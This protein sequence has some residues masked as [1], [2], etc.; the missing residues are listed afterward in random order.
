MVIKGATP[1]IPRSHIEK[2]LSGEGCAPREDAGEVNQGQATN[3]LS[4]E[5]DGGYPEKCSI[6]GSDREG[7]GPKRMAFH[8]RPRR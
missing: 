5:I 3:E 4:Y 2:E 1:Q 7:A 8:G 6:C